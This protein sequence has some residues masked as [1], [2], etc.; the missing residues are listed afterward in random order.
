MFQIQTDSTSTGTVSKPSLQR[1]FVVRF[2][3]SSASSAAGLISFALTGPAMCRVAA[4]DPVLESLYLG[5]VSGWFWS[6][7]RMW[8]H[9]FEARK[10]H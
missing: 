1:L 8:S 3:V 6:L 4:I 5:L 7:G 10:R 9:T 2:I